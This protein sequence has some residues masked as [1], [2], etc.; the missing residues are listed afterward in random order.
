MQTCVKTKGISIATALIILLFAATAPFDHAPKAQETKA[1]KAPQFIHQTDQIPENTRTMQ[2]NLLR[3]ATSGDLE[4]LRHIFE[5]N[6]L[7]PVI[8]D[9]HVS[10]PIAHWQQTSID[11]TARDTMA[12]IAEVF[13]LPGIK[14]KE[15]DFVWPYLARMPLDKLTPAQQI[16]L[17][18]LAGPKQASEMLKTNL[19]N[20]YEAKIGKDGTWHS[21]KR[22]RADQAKS[23]P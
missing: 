22:I 1:R 4:E 12:L 10:D 14:T 9:D 23:K 5:E 18:R 11:G 2:E 3:A 16:D 17:F 7:A 8:A 21:L 19:Y 20:Y 15:G 13:S 6:E